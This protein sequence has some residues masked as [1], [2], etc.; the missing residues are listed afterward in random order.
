MTHA[1]LDE[2]PGMG[3]ALPASQA[4]QKSLLYAPGVGL[5]VPLRHGDHSLAEVAP[6]DAQ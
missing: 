1:L 2:L 3:F 4:L 6:T 5:Y